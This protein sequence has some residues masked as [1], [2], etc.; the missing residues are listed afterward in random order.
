VDFILTAGATMVCYA[1]TPAMAAHFHYL[2]Q[3][4]RSVPDG[5][6]PYLMDI[7]ALR[8]S[9]F[10]EFTLV[11]AHGI[12]TFPSFHTT[13]VVLFCYSLR[14]TWLYWPMALLGVVTILSIPNIGGHYLIDIPAGAAVAASAIFVV[15]RWPAASFS[16]RFG[17]GRSEPVL[18]GRGPQRR[19]AGSSHFS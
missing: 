13:L 5:I 17:L 14:S 6:Y 10:A 4:Q 8:N 9:T 12:V 1:F 3:N 19:S 11:H 15:R 18:E 7:V 2:V 16:A